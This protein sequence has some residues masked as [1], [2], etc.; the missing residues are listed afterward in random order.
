MSEKMKTPKSDRRVFLKGVAVAGGAV[1]VAGGSAVADVS[2]GK[3]EA[4]KAKAEGSK[5]YHE[6]DHIREYYRLAQF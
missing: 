6:T 1:A 5:G 3:P 2:G 4:S